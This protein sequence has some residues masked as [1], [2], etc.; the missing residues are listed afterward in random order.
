MSDR[1]EE[2][3][4][5]YVN[6]TLNDSDRAWMDQYLRDHPQALQNLAYHQRLA[7]QMQ[8]EFDD[9]PEDIGLQRVLARIQP[10]A[11]TKPASS[12]VKKTEPKKSSWLSE[13]LDGAWL[14]PAFAMCLLV[15]AVQS[16]ILFKPATPD[17]PLYRGEAPSAVNEGYLQVNF[18][19]TISEAELRVLLISAQARFVGGPDQ[20]GA[21]YLAVP[22]DQLPI[23]LK[24]LQEQSKVLSATTTQAPAAK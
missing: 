22:N 4:P 24:M 13:L 5:W 8:R 21:Y 10:N 7:Q 15:V 20:T 3:L 18:D 17:Q 19:P 6:G 16:V 14:K 9:V 2:L 12:K 23:A 1:F 11:S